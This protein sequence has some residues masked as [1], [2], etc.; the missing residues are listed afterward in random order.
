MV[1]GPW[2]MIA[3]WH[4]TN[5]STHWRERGQEMRR[6]AATVQEIEA[7]QKMLW[8][9]DDYD[10]WAQRAETRLDRSPE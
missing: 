10:R 9:A 7:R 8:I 2:G 5:D 3:S 4:L 6:L 1:R